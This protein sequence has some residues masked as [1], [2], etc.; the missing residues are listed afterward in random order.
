MHYSK[1]LFY[2]VLTNK[3]GL[4]REEIS[5]EKSFLDLGANSLDM[6]ELII[7]LENALN[8][9]ITDEVAD[10]FKTVGDLEKYLFLE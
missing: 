7:E 9:I 2:E 6:V 8:I 3:F 1:S 5:S 4:S 10:N